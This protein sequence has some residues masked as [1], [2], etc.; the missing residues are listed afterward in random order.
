MAV[1]SGPTV[2][3]ILAQ[4]GFT[5]EDL[6]N[7]TGIAR[8]ESG[9]KTDAIRTDNP[10]GQTGDW[11]LFQINAVNLPQLRNIGITSMNQLLD[12]VTNAR[13]AKYL[14]DQSGYFP[15]GMGPNGWQAG[16]DPLLRV[17][18]NEARAAVEQASQMGLLGQA[19]LGGPGGSSGAISAF[20][21]PATSSSGPVQLPQDAQVVRVD[22]S[23]DIWA[24]FDV[25]GVR[26]GYKID[27]TPGAVDWKSRPLQ[28]ISQA[29]FATVINAGDSGELGTVTETFG[30]FKGFWDS[31]LAQVMGPFNPA[32]NDPEVIRVLAEFAAR[33]DMD[34][35]ELQNKL[36]RTQWYQQHTQSELEWNGLSAAE[37]QLRRD[38]AAARA[39]DTWFQYAGERIDPNDPRIKNYVDQ[40]ASGKLGWGAFSQIVKTQALSNPESPY[41]RDLRTEQEA[42]R[43]R[44]IDIENTAQNIRTTLQRWGLQWTNGEIM[45]WA[46]RIVEK[47]ASDDDLMQT[48]KQ[49]AAVLYPWKD[50]ELETIT[51]AQ[52]WLSVYERRME[53]AGSLTDPKIQ[54]AL[55]AGQTPWDFEQE[56]K[57]SSEWLTTRNAEE[58]MIG[59]MAETSKR[60][61]FF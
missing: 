45:D 35:A 23:M 26:L 21:G 59:M 56:L 10:G 27:L 9:W 29:D 16:G 8:R 61:G 30:N 20:G 50:P 2:A 37:Q 54:K 60:M 52:P 25:G 47:L 15:W 13:A 38:E 43:Q 31:V 19:Y 55:T 11:G 42:Q 57:R 58:E 28:V 12:P 49:Q 41:A 6:V 32:R 34:P 48:L 22:G 46:K 3:Q 1:L 18:L 36:Q 51:A 4:V 40:L 24:V 17:N 33:P 7:F 44:P 53:K 14:F 39:S 5:G